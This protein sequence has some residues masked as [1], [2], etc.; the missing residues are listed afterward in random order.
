MLVLDKVQADKLDELHLLEAQAKDGVKAIE[1]GA[2]LLSLAVHRIYSQKLYLAELDDKGLPVYPTQTAYEPY[3]L[4]HLGVSRQTLYNHYTPARLAMGSTFNLTEEEYIQTGGKVAWSVATKEFLDYD[5]D[6]A[7]VKSLADGRPLDSQAFVATLRNIHRGG[8]SELMLRP[9]QVRQELNNSLGFKE[10]H[11]A[12]IRYM[13]GE[14][15]LVLT[16]PLKTI[17]AVVNGEQIVAGYVTD[18]PSVVYDDLMKRL[19]IRK[20]K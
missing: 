3:L 15:N 7:E 1:T 16:G 8:P 17:I 20:E 19:N 18:I 14:A 10:E 6:T 5:E 4:Q 11:Q 13:E 12:P 2:N 9:S